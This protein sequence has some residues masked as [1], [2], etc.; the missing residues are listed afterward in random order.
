[1][2]MD[3]QFPSGFTTNDYV[4]F[5]GELATMYPRAGAYAGAYDLLAL[6]W[7]VQ[8]PAPVTPIN[9]PTAPPLL[10]LAGKHD[11]AT[12]FDQTL[13]L[14]TALGNGSYLVTSEGQGHYQMSQNKCTAAAAAAYLTD[15][16]KPPATTSCASTFP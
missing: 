11:P 13:R 15:P 7:P 2:S 3:L 5:M 14:Q 9:A 8:R 6:Q 1:M 4:A 10:L 16:T 12:N